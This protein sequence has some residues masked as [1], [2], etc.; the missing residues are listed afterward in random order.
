MP[1]RV[2]PA[3]GPKKAS[4]KKPK[5]QTKKPKSP[6]SQWFDLG[7]SGGILA[8]SWD[9]LGRSWVSPGALGKSR[10]S[11]GLGGLFSP[12]KGFI[13]RLS[14]FKREL[15]RFFIEVSFTKLS[16]NCAENMSTTCKPN[17]KSPKLPTKKKNLQINQSVGV[18]GSTSYR[19][20]KRTGRPIHLDSRYERSGLRTE[21]RFME[22]GQKE[23]V[24]GKRS[25]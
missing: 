19:R 11:L 6:T 14:P 9:G 16:V 4:P 21:K 13:G 15:E 25:K 1:P 10:G 20:R 3:Y 12:S 23:A 18:L 17:K 7:V 2:R 8:I 5:S 22:N 24:H